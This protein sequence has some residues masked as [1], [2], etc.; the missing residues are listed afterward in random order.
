[1]ANTP[2]LS[3]AAQRLR[4]LYNSRSGGSQDAAGAPHMDAADPLVQ[5]CRLAGVRPDAKGDTDFFPDVESPPFCWPQFKTEVKN[6]LQSFRW[7]PDVAVDA[8]VFV[9]TSKDQLEA[10]MAVLPPLNGGRAVSEELLER[11][12]RDSGVEAGVLQDSF[13]VLNDRQGYMRLTKVAEG[14]KPVNGDDAQLLDLITDPNAKRWKEDEHGRIN[15]A[16]K[17]WIMNVTAGQKL[18]EIVPPT[19]G[20]DGYDVFGKSL[21]AKPGRPLKKP[22]G[23]NTEISDDGRYVLASTE[24]HFIN[25]KDRITVSD[26]LTINGNIDY[27]TGNIRVN[28]TVIIHGNVMPNFRVEAKHDIIIHGTVEG[29]TVIAGRDLNILGGVMAAREGSVAAG[30]DLRCKFME[31][32]HGYAGGDAYFENLILCDI[33]AEGSIHVTSGRGSVIG[34]T[35]TAMGD[36]RVGVAGNRT[37]RSTHLRI[38]GTPDFLARKRACNEDLEDARATRKAAEENIRKLEPH[39]NN[40]QVAEVL[41]HQTSIMNLSDIKITNLKKKLD[42]LILEEKATERHR[43][44]AD[45]MYPNVSVAIGGFALVIHQELRHA[46]FA[47]RQGEIRMISE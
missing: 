23:K 36:I 9:W 2:E 41:S 33:S 42:D 12:L 20:T 45:R 35:L 25:D 3:E 1:M 8:D 30:R 37:Y 32:G 11:A 21:P 18:G 13:G 4:A 43:I 7:D 39:K 47:L 10:W 17:N 19:E 29:A 27:E 38:E 34:G 14:K 46:V 24:G 26:V 15:F 22:N 28:G 31:N 5:M 16:E 6:R 44:F 40:P